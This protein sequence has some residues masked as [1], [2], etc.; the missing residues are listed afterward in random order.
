M[1]TQYALTQRQRMVERARSTQVQEGYERADLPDRRF[2]TVIERDP[3]LEQ[4]PPGGIWPGQSRVTVTLDGAGDV[5]VEA[6]CP[7]TVRAR[8]GDRVGVMRWSGHDWVIVFS[9]GLAGGGSVAH[10][11]VWG[12]S[13]ELIGA[14][15]Q[16]LATYSVLGSRNQFFAKEADWLYLGITVVMTCYS[17]ATNTGL[18]LGVR[19]T[20]Q[21]TGAVT[22]LFVTHFEINPASTRTTIV[23]QTRD[24]IIDPGPYKAQLVWKRSSGSG[25]LTTSANDD[26]YSLFLQELPVPYYTKDTPAWPGPPA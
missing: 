4:A 12:W 8:P 3:G 19:V 15:T 17:T 16:T 5:A 22:D 24:T 2:G 9:F 20:S 25:T 21:D 14:Y 23:G 18:D 10:Y 13:S 7:D 1:V 26:Y 6:F 11:P